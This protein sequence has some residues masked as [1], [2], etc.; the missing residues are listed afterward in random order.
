MGA[1]FVINPTSTVSLPF[2]IKCLRNAIHF[3]T[4]ACVR[5]I[6]FSDNSLQVKTQQTLRFLFTICSKK[7]VPASSMVFESAICLPRHS[8]FHIVQSFACSSLRIENLLSYFLY[9]FNM[10]CMLHQLQ[11]FVKHFWDVFS[12]FHKQPIAKRFPQTRK[13]PVYQIKDIR[14]HSF[15][16]VDFPAQCHLVDSI[17]SFIWIWAK[18]YALHRETVKHH[19]SMQR[20]F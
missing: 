19:F 1:Y 8:V 9:R 12:F 5:N 4:N 15:A 16:I 2:C 18:K 11:P 14:Y 13:Q 17:I 3:L 6:T 20:I 10:C 7:Q